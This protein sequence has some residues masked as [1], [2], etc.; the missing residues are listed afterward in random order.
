M[1]MQKYFFYFP[2]NNKFMDLLTLSTPLLSLS[3]INTYHF[4]L[5]KIAPDS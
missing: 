3:D 1:I 2:V 4:L 5:E